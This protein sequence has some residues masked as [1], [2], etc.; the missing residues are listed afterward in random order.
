VCLLGDGKG[1]F[2]FID[3]DKSGL[4]VN[5]EIRDIDSFIN[6]KGEKTLLFS[7]NNDAP[8]LFKL[9]K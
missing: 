5:G 6:Y 1:D 4:K 3:V 8:Q 9:N 2:E 7:R